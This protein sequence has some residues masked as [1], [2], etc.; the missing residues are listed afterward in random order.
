MNQL[1][2]P[3]GNNAEHVDY[4]GFGHRPL[5]GADNIVSN[6]SVCFTNDK[7]QWRFGR[8]RNSTNLPISY[9]T[10]LLYGRRCPPYFFFV[11]KYSVVWARNCTLHV[12]R[13]DII[14]YNRDCTAIF[15]F[16]VK[17]KIQ[18]YK[19]PYEKKKVKK[20]TI[21]YL[22]GY[23]NNFETKASALYL[24]APYLHRFRNPITS[25]EH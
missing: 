20:K 10:G 16:L 6:S 24:C 8:C 19:I 7:S 12:Y 18:I 22:V 11:F 23:R 15:F 4:Y 5:W 9:D 3:H 13:R 14:L 25:N 2:N 17:H 1:V 21:H